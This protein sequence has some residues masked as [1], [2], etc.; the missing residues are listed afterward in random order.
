MKIVRLTSK[1][2]KRLKAVE[3]APDGNVVVVGGRNGQGKTSVLDSIAYALGGKDVICREPIRRGEERAE[4]TCDLGE[5]IVRRTFTAGGGGALTVETKDGAR[6]TSPQGRLDDLIGSLSFDPLAFAR[7]DAATQ[8]DTLRRLMGLDFSKLDGERV[9]LFE[10]RTQ[11]NRDGKALAARH[12]AMQKWADAPAEEV[13]ANDVLIQIEAERVALDG[14]EAERAAA[15]DAERALARLNENF[16]AQRADFEELSAIL[17]KK[18]SA[19]NDTAIKIES[20]KVTASNARARADSHGEEADTI[21]P[22]QERLTQIEEIN[23]KVRD[24]AA[25]ATLGADLDKLRAYS[26]SLTESLAAIDEEKRAAVAAVQFPV[27]GLGFGE[28][29]VTLTGIPFDQAS[30]AEQLRVSVAIG[31]ALNPKL[32]VLLIRDASLLDAES[33]RLVAEMA[34][35]HDA[36]LWLERVED[37]G[38]TVVIEDGSVVGAVEEVQS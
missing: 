34:D 7:M 17:K 3:I 31:I 20:A 1:N 26:Q 24:N 15:R 38:S 32:R 6:F 21:G 18:E 14:R 35:K 4:V 37:E 9:R 27:G 23:R 11:V 16:A 12:A 29:G 5:L 8:A 33:L 22:L 25:A 28:G 10:E 30:A 13:S 2:I 19:L 36:Q